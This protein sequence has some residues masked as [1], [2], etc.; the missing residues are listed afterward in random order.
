MSEKFIPAF[1]NFVDELRQIWAKETKDEVRMKK[2]HAV[3]ESTL[4][5][6]PEFINRSKDWPS[7]EGRKNLLFY[8]DPDYGFVINGVVREPGR[9][10]SVHDHANAW[11]LYGLPDGTETLERFDVIDDRRSEGYAKVVLTSAPKGEAGKAD[12]V[13]PYEVHAEQGSDI[14]SVAVILRS[15]ELVGKILQGRYDR[16]TGKYYEGSGP[17]QIP[18]PLTAQ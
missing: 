3:M 15:R 17:D 12:L 1:Q 6:D 10:G 8:T 18:Y 16:D 9:T 7:T 11:V 2:A 4:L 13:G 14:R 5:N